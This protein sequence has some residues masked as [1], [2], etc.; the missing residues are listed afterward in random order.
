MLN[1]I[2][3]KKIK[4][5]PFSSYLLKYKMSTRIPSMQSI[6]LLNGIKYSVPNSQETL[7]SSRSYN[8]GFI[9][10]I[11][12]IYLSQLPLVSTINIFRLNIRSSI[13]FRT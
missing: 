6:S 4:H 3:Y 11:K 9:H 2:I 7:N 12:Y 5:L 10:S 13:I 8:Y 1:E